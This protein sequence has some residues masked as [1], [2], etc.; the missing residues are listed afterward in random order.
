MSFTVSRPVAVLTNVLDSTN[1]RGSCS[2][3]KHNNEW[4]Q[5]VVHDGKKLK[6]AHC[7]PMLREILSTVP[8]LQIASSSQGEMMDGSTVY[9]KLEQT[10]VLKHFADESDGQHCEHTRTSTG[11]ACE[12]CANSSG[13][14]RSSDIG[15]CRGSNTCVVRITLGEVSF[16]C[17]DGSTH[18]CRS[19][20]L[21]RCCCTRRLCLR[22]CCCVCDNDTCT[23]SI[24]SCR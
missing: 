7:K 13:N 8:S 6:L 2:I 15:D 20:S 5:K 21:R 19:K 17:G 16:R 14:R 12:S 22:H 18:T 9:V 4:V 24:G 3:S 1:T 11:G 23:T 10:L